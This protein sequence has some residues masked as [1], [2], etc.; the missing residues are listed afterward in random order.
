VS[1]SSRGTVGD[2]LGSRTPPPPEPLRSRILVAL[3]D[4]V[5]REVAATERVCLDAAERVLTGL[6]VDG[7]GE[8]H[9]AADLL[10]ADALVTYALEFA[11]ESPR[12][13]A[14]RATRALERFGQLHEA[15]A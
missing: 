9:E 7:N 6:F 13:F 14:D 12:A 1:Q 4:A 11:A 5:D 8:R 3:G 2:W 15:R 10:A